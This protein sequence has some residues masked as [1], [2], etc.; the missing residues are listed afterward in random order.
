MIYLCSELLLIICNPD[1]TQKQHAESKMAWKCTYCTIPVI[2]HSRTGNLI[3]GGG[4]K[5][6]KQWLA[7]G[8]KGW[9]LTGKGHERISGV[10]V[11]F[12]TGM[13]F[14]FTQVYAFIKTQQMYTRFVNFTVYEFYMANKANE[15]LLH[16]YCSGTLLVCI[17]CP[18][19]IPV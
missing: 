11:P 19:C 13:R 9:S 14:W 8:C 6:S 16:W 5:L 10:M 18:N 17:Y 7:L 4:K 12:H 1:K 2:W 15:N 3:Y